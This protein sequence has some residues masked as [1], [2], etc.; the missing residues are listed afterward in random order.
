MELLGQ[1][2]GNRVGK[3]FALHISNKGFIIKHLKNFHKPV[4]LDQIIFLTVKGLEEAFHE[5]EYP[6]NKHKLNISR[7]QQNVN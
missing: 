7:Y 5:R 1:W 2:K 6:V 4:R 3:I